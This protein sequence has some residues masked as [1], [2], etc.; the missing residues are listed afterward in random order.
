MKSIKNIAIIPA[1][2]GSKRFPGKNVTLFDGHPLLAHSIQ[3]AK[4][5]KEIIDEIVVSTDDNAIKKVALKYG[6]KVIDRPAL[7]SGDHEP[8]ITALM[9]AIE[10]YDSFDNVIL[11]QPT[12]PLRPEKMLKEAYDE[13][14]KGNYSSLMSVSRNKQKLGKID[15]GKFIP[16]NYEIGQRSQDLEPLYYENGLLYITRTNL[17][18]DRK[19]IGE[20]HYSF[21]L[22]H[23][24]AD[25]DI[26]T[27]KD[28]LYAEYI[29]ERTRNL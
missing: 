1:R 12:N 19:I 3:Y 24:F 26:D 28:L 11:L 2:G 25:V 22:D 16:Y 23:A 9:H 7:L 6:A 14:V 15:N 27:P 20:E 17:I 5:N 18:A 21:V 10:T 29:L 8:T 4:M 13:F